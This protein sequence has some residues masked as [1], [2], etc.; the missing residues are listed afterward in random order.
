MD[1]TIF[2]EKVDSMIPDLI[3]GIRKECNRLYDSGAVDTGAY[4]DN[5]LLPKL[6]LT[7]AIQNQVIQYSPPSK[8]GKK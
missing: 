2:I 6:I 1:K 8:E 4:E 5:A 7:V 3:E